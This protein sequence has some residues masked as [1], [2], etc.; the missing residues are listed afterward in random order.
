MEHIKI[1]LYHEY[2]KT[3]KCHEF[4]LVTEN[5]EGSCFMKHYIQWIWFYLALNLKY[6]EIK[7]FPYPVGKLVKSYKFFNDATQQS[8]MIAKRID[9]FYA[10]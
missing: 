7:L 10:K 4:G 5:L 3:E 6:K 8:E 9:S 1:E 2:S